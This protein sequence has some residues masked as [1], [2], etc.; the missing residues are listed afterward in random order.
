MLVLQGYLKVKV[1]FGLVECKFFTITS[2]N[3]NICFFH[4][5]YY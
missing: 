3:N 5:A 1:L 2:T 4:H